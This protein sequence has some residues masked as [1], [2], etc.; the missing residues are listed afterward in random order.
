MPRIE[1]VTGESTSQGASVH[2]V[3][4]SLRDAGGQARDVAREKYEHLRSAAQEY[5]EQGR[6]KAKEWKRV[7][8]QV[9][10]SRIVVNPKI[11]SKSQRRIQCSLPFSAFWQQTGREPQK[12]DYPDLFGF[13]FPNPVRSS[14]RAFNQGQVPGEQ[15]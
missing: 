7:T 6:A 11:D 5:Y 8:P 14:A 3:T 4:Q 10:T 13:R 15:E 1:E 9:R 2:G 12:L